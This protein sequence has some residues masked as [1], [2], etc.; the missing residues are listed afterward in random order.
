MPEDRDAIY[1]LAYDEAKQAVAQQVGALDNL[2]G[3][4]GTLLAVASLSTSFLGGIVLQGKAPHEWL[5]WAAIG[6]FLGA[7]AITLVLLVPR[8]GWVFGTSAKVIIEDYAEGEHPQDLAATHRR[9]ALY[10]E[11]HEDSNAKRLR[12]LYWLF[13]AASV[14]LGGE[15]LLW[16]VVLIRR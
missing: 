13:V 4:A 8:P 14:L 11:G 10:L 6:A 1:Q 9:L 15:I 2:R 7:V 3:R 5:S 12:R 16:L